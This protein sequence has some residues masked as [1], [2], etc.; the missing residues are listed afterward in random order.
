M[1]SDNPIIPV[2]GRMR[3]EEGRERERPREDV[4]ESQRVIRQKHRDRETGVENRAGE[5]ER[6]HRGVRKEQRRKARSKMRTRLFF[7]L[8]SCL[9]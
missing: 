9:P 3:V 1:A 8:C 2:S 6:N 7:F 5:K 4:T